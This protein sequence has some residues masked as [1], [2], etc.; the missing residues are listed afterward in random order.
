MSV[1]AACA[2]EGTAC[3]ACAASGK[4][5][6]PAIIA[7]KRRL[8]IGPYLWRVSLQL[9]TFKEE[10][11]AAECLP[12]VCAVAG[13]ANGRRDRRDRK[14]RSS[15]FDWMQIVRSAAWRGVGIEEL[16]RL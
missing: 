1:E 11:Q 6:M 5:A 4:A 8:R 2:V 10:I 12:W 13:I 16:W 9:R 7:M 15:G 3:C 14:R